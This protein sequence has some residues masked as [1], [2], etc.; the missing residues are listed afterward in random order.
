M[1]SSEKLSS[2]KLVLRQSPEQQAA[3]DRLLAEQQDPA[4][5]NYRRWLTPE[6]YADRFGIAQEDIAKVTDWLARQNLR[7]TSVAR[8]RNAISFS[9]SAG[10]VEKAFATEIHRY[11]TGGRRHF[12]NVTEPSIPAALS[13]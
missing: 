11:Q 4:S 13:R 2:V 12:A 3:L 5:P 10:D 1:D 7:V 6:E 8:G 9:G